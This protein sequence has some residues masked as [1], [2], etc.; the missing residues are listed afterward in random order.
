M[1]HGAGTL[2]DAVVAF[3]VGRA[4]LE[5]AEQIQ[6]V[7][8]GSLDTALL[9]AGAQPSLITQALERATDLRAA[10]EDELCERSDVRVEVSQAIR[11]RLVPLSE[12]AGTLLVAASVGSARVAAELLGV[13]AEV[14][15]VPEWRLELELARR[16]GRLLPE[17]FAVLAARLIGP[18]SVRAA[19]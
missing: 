2:R 4:L 8:G 12:R 7:H 3:G 14:R 5:R 15:V 13:P 1:K 10:T 16:Y 19:V 11:W 18:K 9:E 6:S 17:R